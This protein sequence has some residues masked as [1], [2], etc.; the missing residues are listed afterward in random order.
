MN[1]NTLQKQIIT[2]GTGQ[3][4][5]QSG[6]TAFVHYTGKFLDGNVFDSSVTRGSP[7]SFN[8]NQGNVIRGWD[9]CVSSMKQGEK[10]IL[11]CPPEFGYGNRQVGPIPPNSTLIFEIELLGWN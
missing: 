6:V 11:T 4:I 10:C 8:L 5:P 9:L 7:F 1:T 3:Q 2:E